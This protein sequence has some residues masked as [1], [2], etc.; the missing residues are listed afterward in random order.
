[1]LNLRETLVDLIVSADISLYGTDKS[2]AEVYADYLIENLVTIQSTEGE[3]DNLRKQVK[4]LRKMNSW[5]SVEDDLPDEDV[6][7]LV[8]I[9]KSQW[10]TDVETDTDRIHNKRWVRWGSAVTHWAPLPHFAYTE[11]KEGM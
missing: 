7:V 2:Y 5:T 10:D 11:K 3:L 1:M 8:R 4:E 9:D 6:R